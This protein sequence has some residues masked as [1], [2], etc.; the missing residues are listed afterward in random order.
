MDRAL[1]ISTGIGCGVLCS[2]C[3]QVTIGRAYK[4]FTGPSSL[5]FETYK[6]C[7]DKLPK[8]VTVNFTGFYEPFLNQACTDMILYAVEAGHEVRLSTTVMGLTAEQVDRFKHVDFVKFA[9][10][11]PDTKGLTRIIVDDTYMAALTRLIESDISNIGFHVHEGT[12]GPEAVH[13]RVDALLSAHGVEPE[14]RWILTRAG[15]IDIAGVAPPERLTGELALC[16]RVYQNVLLPSGDV[17]LCCMDWDLKHVI[18]NLLETDY[19]ALLSG[20]EFQKV[21]R[22]Q[23]DDNIDIL[24]RTCE[25][26]RTKKDVRTQEFYANLEAQNADMATAGSAQ[27]S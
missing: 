22:A 19:D 12:E 23:V 15:N 9:V 27:T 2:Y 16:P 8:D 18:G 17:A 4:Q 25:V 10:H 11:L 5:S 20:A 1:L 26:A 13:E 7:V 21:L 6:A 14:N 3:P 24:C